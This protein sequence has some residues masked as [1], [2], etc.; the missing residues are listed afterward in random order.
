MCELVCSD[1]KF[2]NL[3]S[4]PAV[5]KYSIRMHKTS[6]VVRLPFYELPLT[7]PRSLSEETLAAVGIYKSTPFSRSRCPWRRMLQDL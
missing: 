4:D 3:V 1:C 6:A 7:V 2:T 5:K